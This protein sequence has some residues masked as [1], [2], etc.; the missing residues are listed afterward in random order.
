MTR[1][2]E[3]AIRHIKTRADA[4]AVKEIDKAL[5]QEPKILNTID[6]AIDASNGDTNYFVGFRNGLRYTKSLI[7]GEEPQFESCAEQEPKS[8]K[9]IPVSERLPELKQRILVSYETMDDGK[10]VDVT[11]YDK[12]GFLIGKAQAWMPLPKPYQKGGKE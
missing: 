12:Y 6:F 2:L 4:W 5:S 11:T 3:K 8:G 7:D 1:E 10:K 9:W